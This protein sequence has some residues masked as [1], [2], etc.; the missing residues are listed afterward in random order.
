ME[1]MM[2]G[3]ELMHTLTLKCKLEP[4]MEKAIK[5]IMSYSKAA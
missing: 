5:R 4:L 3:M 2:C 1:D